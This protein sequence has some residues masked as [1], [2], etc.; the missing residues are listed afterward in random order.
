M[1]SPVGEVESLLDTVAVVNVDVDIQHP[2]MKAQQLQ[3]R[4]HEIVDV[5]EACIPPLPSP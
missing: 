3:D 4:Q 5:A 2:G 1:L